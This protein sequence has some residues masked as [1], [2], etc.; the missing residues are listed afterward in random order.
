MLKTKEERQTDLNPQETS[1]WLEA[2]DQIVDEAGPDR[3]TYLLEKLLN[4]A[5]DFGVSPPRTRLPYVNTIP[6]HEEVPYPGDRAIERRIKSLIRWNAAAMVVRANKYDP[7]LVVIYPLMHHLPRLARSVSTTSSAVATVI[8]PEISFITRATP[9]RVSILVLFSKAGSV[10][11]ICLIS[12]TNCVTR[13]GFPPTPIRGSCRTSGSSPRCPWALVPSTAIYNARFLRYLENR[14]IIPRT[15]RKVYAFLG[16][17]EM[18]E[19]ESTGALHIA[20]RE[21]LDNLI[22]I[23]N[24]NSAAS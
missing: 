18:D 9:R 7:T 14:E 12:V 24:C 17:G 10:N 20:S 3:A 1:E 23:I 22:F 4:R 15:D 5:A 13:P 11:S 16:D 2:L 6:V 8:R 19:P 21:K